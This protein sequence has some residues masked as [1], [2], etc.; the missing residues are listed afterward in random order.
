MKLSDRSDLPRISI[1]TPS[2]NQSDYIEDT[3]LS[4][5]RQDYP[6]IEYIVMDG[7]S[8][9]GS[10]DIIQ[11]YNDRLAFW[12]SEPDRGQ[13]EA[14]N[15]GLQRATG[16][17]VAW[18]NSDDLYMAG[19]IRG[20]VEALRAHPEAGMVYADGYMVDAAGYL[21]DP[22]RYGDYDVL[23]LLCF[24]VILQPTV[25]MRRSALESVGYLGEDY[26]L[27]LDHDLWIRIANRFPIVHVSSFW[28]VERT[29][30]DAKTI[31]QAA[32]W[33]G[34]AESFL[35]RA[36]ASDE[37]GSLIRDHSRRILASLDTFAARRLIDAG[38]YRK[39][40]GRFFRGLGRYPPVVFR[41]W[42][43]V[44]QAVFSALGLK[45]LFFAYRRNRRRLQH[46]RARIYVG[47][48]GGELLEG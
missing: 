38:Q 7:G 42:Y 23:D 40:V 1:V 14:I 12:T 37:L 26:H 33:V 24:D 44:I 41:Y 34:E 27:V 43:K 18:L 36:E 15:K 31:A 48:Q 39:A 46:G 35:T 3:L 4:V 6:H 29:H 5:L 47:K 22:H 11:R 19:A 13:A 8:T 16:E 45:V 17:I 9:D 2:Y 28:A 20:A 32:G 25:F 21:L 10:Q 30:V